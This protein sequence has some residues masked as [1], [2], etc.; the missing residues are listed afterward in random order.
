MRIIESSPCDPALHS[1]CT[2]VVVRIV[3]L[4]SGILMDHEK[5]EALKQTYLV[6][7]EELDKPRPQEEL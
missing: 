4:F 7:R 2:K 1:I 3:N 6:L 5:P